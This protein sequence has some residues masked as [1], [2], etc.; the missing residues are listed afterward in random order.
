MTGPASDFARAHRIDKRQVRRSF[1]R[2]ARDYDAAA[3]L[4]QRVEDENLRR[5]DLVRV[6]PQCVLDIGCGT[7]RGSRALA[8]RYRGA[9]VVSADL[10]PGMLRVARRRRRW[11]GRQAFVCAD[12]EQLPFAAQSFDLVHASLVMQWCNDLDATLRGLAGCLRPGGLLTFTTFGPDTLHE[13]RGAWQG[14]DDTHVSAFIDMHDIG[15]AL[16]RSGFETPVLDVESYCLTYA[17]FEDVARDLKA[18][19]AR[20][21]TAGRSRGLTGRAAWARA[22]EAYENWREDGRLPATYEVVY[23]HAWRAER[24][25][26]APGE[27]VAQWHPRR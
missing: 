6:Q 18:I 7:G 19:G 26:V 10:A 2:S 21:A 9:R 12:L 5:L 15:D 13:L 3:V 4:Q 1:D 14:Q 11:F 24:P 20:N 17:T 27:A 23:G 25:L 8:R 22:R 16:G